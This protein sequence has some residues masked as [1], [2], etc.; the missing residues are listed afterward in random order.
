MQ[1]ALRIRDR[2]EACRRL[3]NEGAEATLWGSAITR[4]DKNADGLWIAH[5]DEYAIPVCY[6]PFCGQRLDA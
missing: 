6:C 3:D 1:D 2:L 5:N 4:I